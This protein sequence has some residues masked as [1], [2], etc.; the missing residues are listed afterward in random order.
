MKG[1][2]LEGATLSISNSNFI[3]P[4]LQPQKAT[5]TWR[6]LYAY[7]LNLLVHVAMYQK[8]YGIWSKSLLENLK[9]PVQQ[10]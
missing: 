9:I 8:E 6:V 3:Y 5:T 7:F 2:W 1:G 4:Q 10:G